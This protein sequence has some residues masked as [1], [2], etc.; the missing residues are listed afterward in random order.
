MSSPVNAEWLSDYGLLKAALLRKRKAGLPVS[1]DE[2][3]YFNSM[4]GKLDSKLRI[5]SA[6]P[7]SNGLVGSEIARRQV[8]VENLK[9][10]V[11]TLKGITLPTPVSTSNGSGGGGGDGDEDDDEDEVDFSQMGSGSSIEIGGGG[12]GSSSSRSSCSN[13][14]LGSSFSASG[15]R[16]GYAPVTTSGKGLAMRLIDMVGL[17]DD[18]LHDLDSGVGRL[19]GLATDMREETNMH[20]RLLDNMEGNIDLATV[21]LHAEAK[22]A[23]QLKEK[24][25]GLRLYLCLVLEVVVLVLLLLTLISR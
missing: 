7:Q 3:V 12:G 14:S 9:K 2:I 16:T 15:R 5:L 4:A 23:A 25:F 10:Q 18:L 1:H 8:L 6:S 11:I 20:S 21:S 24:E 17:Q 13:S 19:H 22:R